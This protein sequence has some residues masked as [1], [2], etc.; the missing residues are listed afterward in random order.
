M[1]VSVMLTTRKAAPVTTGAAEDEKPKTEK[2]RPNAE[3][4]IG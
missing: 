2:S 1:P 3:S 4:Q